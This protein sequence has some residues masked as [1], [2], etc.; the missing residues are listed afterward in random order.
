MNAY[1]AGLRE[2]RSARADGARWWQGEGIDLFVWQ[3]V[4]GVV[5]DFQLSIEEHGEAQTLS[6]RRGAGFTVLRVDAERA[7]DGHHARTPLLVAGGSLDL[8]AVL[9]R[10]D[11]ASLEIEG[12]LRVAMLKL[13]REAADE[14][15]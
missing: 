12:P 6:W 3:D 8:R 15:P 10:F 1:G 11:E 5:S 4:A 2:I 14:A 9:R 13:L 7:D